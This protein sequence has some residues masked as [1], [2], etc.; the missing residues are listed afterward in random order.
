MG[1]WFIGDKTVVFV[2]VRLLDE[3]PSER[4]ERLDLYHAIKEW[5]GTDVLGEG[6]SRR[7]A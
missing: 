5:L 3:G 6:I 2:T 1:G 7:A 4:H